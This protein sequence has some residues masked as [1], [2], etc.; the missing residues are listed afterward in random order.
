M[1][2]ST[3]SLNKD[4]LSNPTE[5]DQPAYSFKIQSGL[6]SKETNVI[7]TSKYSWYNFFPKILFEQFSKPI[8]LYFVII[9]IFEV[10]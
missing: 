5:N 3:N 4:K 6:K 10:W 9:S 1:E 8:N 2:N 7:N